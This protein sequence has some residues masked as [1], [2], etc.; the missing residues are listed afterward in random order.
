MA[1]AAS[2]SI[3]PVSRFPSTSYVP[4]ALFGPSP[5]HLPQPAP[6]FPHDLEA[7]QPARAGHPERALR[8]G[9]W[10]FELTLATQRPADLLRITPNLK[11]Y[12]VE[13]RDIKLLLPHIPGVVGISIICFDLDLSSPKDTS[14]PLPGLVSPLLCCLSD[15]NF[16]RR[17]YISIVYFYLN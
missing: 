5:P 1:S 9:L 14:G 12:L 15:A 7:T 11:H 2:A 3:V 6:F 13:A 8:A 10:A 4:F 16:P 17:S